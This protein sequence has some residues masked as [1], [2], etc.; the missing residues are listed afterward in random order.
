MFVLLGACDGGGDAN[1]NNQG[2]NDAGLDAVDDVVADV[3]DTSDGGEPDSDDA[4]DGGD[5]SDTDGG[6]VRESEPPWEEIEDTCPPEE[7]SRTPYAKARAPGDAVGEPGILWTTDPSCPDSNDPRDLDQDAHGGG[8][9]YGVIDWE[10][11]PRE[12]LL[13]INNVFNPHMFDNPMRSVSVL[14]AISGER[15]ACLELPEGSYEIQAGVSVLLDDPPTLYIPHTGPLMPSSSDAPM[16]VGVMAIDIRPSQQTPIRFQRVWD[17]AR[18]DAA[19]V[20]VTL[21]E[22]G[23]LGV[24]VTG[25]APGTGFVAIDAASGEPYWDYPLTRSGMLVHGHPSDGFTLRERNLA[26]ST[27]EYTLLN[28]C[29]EE[30]GTSPNIGVPLGEYWISEMQIGNS[31][32]SSVVVRNEAGEEKLSATC[33]R[34]VAVDEQTVACMVRSSQTLKILDLSELK[35]REISLPTQQETSGDSQLFSAQIVAL[36]NRRVFL[37]AGIRN[38]GKGYNRFF[39]YNIESEELSLE[40]VLDEMPLSFDRPWAM[41]HRGVLYGLRDGNTSTVKAVAIQTNLR[42]ASSPWPF[43][44]PTQYGAG[45]DNRGWVDAQ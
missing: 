34:S 22:A 14:D 30:V 13:N 19:S 45:N 25:N 26:E 36:R 2:D 38:S 1:A 33:N 11:E 8:F 9:V 16:Y 43:G 35:V 23:L 7:L 18:S 32:D 5:T 6:E 42:P 10:G 15:L 31:A 21:N 37:A 44:I 29:G 39:V 27:W 20:S 40:Q 17:S 28:R 41:S 24:A 4:R 3:A 12:V